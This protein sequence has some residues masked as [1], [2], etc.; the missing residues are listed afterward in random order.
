M[1]MDLGQPNE[2]PAG[3]SPDRFEEAA[4]DFIATQKAQ[5]DD[6]SVFVTEDTSYMMRRVIDRCRKNF[7]GQYETPHD[8]ITGELKVWVPLTAWTVLNVKKNIDIDQKDILIRPGNPQ[9]VNITPLIRAAIQNTLKKLGFGQLINDILQAVSIDGTAV[10]KTFQDVDKR[11]DKKMV[12]AELVDLLNIW[13]DPAAKSIQDSS[14]IIERIVMSKADVQQSN[15]KLD[16]LEFVNFSMNVPTFDDLVSGDVRSEL[17]FTEFWEFWGKIKKSWITKDEDDDDTWIEG[18]IVTS[19]LGAPSIVH[20]IKKNP[21]KDQM[22]PY[23]EVWYERIQGRWYGKGAAESLFDMQEQMNT[24]VNI[25]K[26]NNLVLQNGIFLVRKGSGLTPEMLGHIRAG[27]GLP[28]TDINRDI[29]QLPVQDFRASSY[30]DEDRVSMWSTRV[31]GSPELSRGELAAASE[32]ATSTL[33]RDRNI[34]DTFILIQEGIGFFVERFILNQVIHQMKDILSSE[35]VIRI[36]GRPEDLTAIDET[37]ITN[38]LRK[39]VLDHERDTGFYPDEIDI[40][41]FKRTQQEGLKKMGKDRFVTYFKTMFDRDIDIEIHVTDE[42]FNRVVAAQQLRDLML[43]FSRIPGLSKLD[44]DA[45][46]G[47]FLNIM[48]IKGEFFL[49]KPKIPDYLVRPRQEQGQQGGF[50]EEFPEFNI[51]PQQTQQGPR[52]LREFPEGVPT[53]QEVVST[54]LRLPQLG[55]PAE[56]QA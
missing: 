55:V 28:V 7:L 41:R 13:I 25:R 52:L 4:L 5:W 49:D 42:R 15:N 48:G 12:K 39:F 23:E 24:I 14:G 3:Y 2:R 56:E 54:A 9:S 10:I 27:G 11:T 31:T 22:R 21:R 33:T 8:S 53:E 32:S 1:V 44:I 47:E 18:V 26:N 35:D 43:A 19:G 38:R 34:K 16:N 17:P 46:I 29:K 50:A 20:S 6:A 36:S 37:I 51:Q 30:A 40:E 45:V